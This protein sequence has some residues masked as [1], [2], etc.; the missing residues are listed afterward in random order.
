MTD[1]AEMT[2]QLE[3]RPSPVLDVV[4]QV[5]DAVRDGQLAPGQR[6]I[7]ADF[8][9]RLGVARST[10]RE[11]FQRLEVEGLLAVERHRGFSIR[12]LTRAEVR[13]IYEVREALDGLAARLSAP[14]FKNHPR[15]LTDLH[16]KLKRA[17]EEVNLHDFTRSNREFHQLIRLRSGNDLVCKTLNLLERSVYHY[18]YRLLVHG[19]AT[20]DSQDEHVQIYDALRVG[21]GEAA[22]HVM[23]AHVRSS[24]AAL[25]NLPDT[26]FA[27]S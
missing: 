5:V 8:A 9:K 20:L 7:E 1:W 21:D 23:R 24:L 2:V 3:N 27:K 14:R 10:V 13:D 25:T 19:R 6:L 22:E 15:E 18:Q 4:A 16:E 12:A 26:V 17:R 11:A